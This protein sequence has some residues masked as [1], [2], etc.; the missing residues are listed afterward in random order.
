MTRILSTLVFAASLCAAAPAMAQLDPKSDAPLDVTAD[1]LE[2]ANTQCSSV[3]R[4]NAEALQGEARLRANVL[5]AFFQARGGG[6]GT[7][8]SNN[9]GDLT[10]LEA[11]GQVYYVA[12]QQRVRGDNAVYDA[13][14]ETLVMTGDVVATQGQ[15]VVRG[16]RM[17]F[18]TRT[19]EGRMVGTAKGRNQAGRP[20]G[21]FYPSKKSS[22]G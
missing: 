9:C 22:G 18:N 5:R 2:V 16:T 20:R 17:V 21:V 7:A 15:N 1:E 14:A 4:G 11:E 12:R 19:G 13:G 8:T 3:W 6:G 10:R